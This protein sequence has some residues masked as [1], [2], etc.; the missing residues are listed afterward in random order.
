M[1]TTFEQVLKGSKALSANER[2]LLAHALIISLEQQQDDNSDA[3]GQT[4][5]DNSATEL[6]SGTV[7]AISWHDIKSRR[8]TTNRAF[9]IFRQFKTTPL[10]MQRIE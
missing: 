4:L 2:A 5:V 6:T 10:A 3:A 7:Q 9:S 8:L 1:T